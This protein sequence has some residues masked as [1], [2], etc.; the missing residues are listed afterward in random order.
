MFS[1]D[2]SDILEKCMISNMKMLANNS[3]TNFR[4][5]LLKNF[6]H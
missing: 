6:K 3:D 4:K 1:T 2:T 5:Q